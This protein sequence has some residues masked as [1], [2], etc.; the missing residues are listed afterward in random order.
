MKE[1]LLD[2]LGFATTVLN[3]MIVAA[4]NII[5]FVVLIWLAGVGARKV[6]PD[7]IKLTRK[8]H[9]GR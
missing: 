3:I 8:Y 7:L 9:R 1:A 2:S 4:I 6:T 5:G